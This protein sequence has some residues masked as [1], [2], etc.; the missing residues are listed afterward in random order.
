VKNDEQRA[1]LP[2]KS[3]KKS[4]IDV[5]GRGPRSQAGQALGSNFPHALVG[6]IAVFLRMQVGGDLDNLTGYLS[7][8][9]LILRVGQIRPHNRQEA[10]PQA[11][12]PQIQNV[13]AVKLSVAHLP[14]SHPVPQIGPKLLDQ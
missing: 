12:P 3:Q 10:E 9:S 8:R 13:A 6:V 4:G 11:E 7:F 14:V 5:V 2:A 1:L